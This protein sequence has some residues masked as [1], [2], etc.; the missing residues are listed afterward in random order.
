MGETVRF[1][2]TFRGRVASA[3]A[4]ATWAWAIVVLLDLFLIRWVADRWWGVAILLFMPRWLFLAPLPFLLLA[5]GWGGRPRH[6]ILQAVVAL[7]VAGPLMRIN[8]PISQAWDRPADGT[9]VRVLTI[10]R[11]E[12][13]FDGDRLIRLIE[14]ERIDLVC[15]QE[16]FP[17]AVGSRKVEDY[18]ASGG[19]H[20]DREHYVA[21]RYPIVDELPPLSDDFRPKGRFPAHMSGVRVRA[22][23][24]VEFGVVSVH[25]PTLRRGFYRLRRH[26][27]E[28]MKQH[29]AWWDRELGRVL[30]GL[31]GIG[32]VPLLIGGDF[33]VP[34]DHASMAALG[35]FFRFAFE[36]AGWGYGYTRPSSWPWFRIDH[37]LGS[38]E[39]AFTRCRVGPDLGS[40]HLPL[41]AEA[42][43]RP[44]ASPSLRAGRRSPDGPD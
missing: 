12:H 30:E 3:S 13:S 10:N 17:Y 6:W 11:G 22:A 2:G 40:D 1:R 21:S 35:G 19:W 41:I 4:I 14:E 18:F 7:V 23:P 16:G 26:D 42:V 24:A 15:F 5:S 44:A 33:N 8:L 20:R 28:G 43:L 31:A 9:R 25:M 27:V 37:I 38:P 36:D 32:P 39:W 34:P 29:L